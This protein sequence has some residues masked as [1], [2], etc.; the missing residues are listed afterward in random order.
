MIFFCLRTQCE[1]GYYSTLYLIVNSCDS[2]MT[3]T[4]P[5]SCALDRR[6]QAYVDINGGGRTNK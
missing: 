2:G 5:M 3:A 6:K 4:D 1:V